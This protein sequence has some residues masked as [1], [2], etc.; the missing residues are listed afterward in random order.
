VT[1]PSTRG[2]AVNNINV[3]LVID[4]SDAFIVT[5]QLSVYDRN[6]AQFGYVAENTKARTSLDI[7]QWRFFNLGT[8]FPISSATLNAFGQITIVMGDIRTGE[9]ILVLPPFLKELRGLSGSVNAGG[10]VFIGAPV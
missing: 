6:N 8:E 5:L 9:G 1:R 4:S 3:T 10:P 2:G 7:S